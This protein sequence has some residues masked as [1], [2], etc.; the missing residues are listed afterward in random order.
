MSS[1][2]AR[3][4]AVD[5]LWR[6]HQRYRDLHGERLAAATTYYGF[7]AV[8]TL[9][10]AGYSLLRVAFRLDPSVADPVLKIIR[11]YYVP[12]VEIEEVAASSR[13]TGVVALFGLVFTGIIWV[14]ALRS[15]QRLIH[16][17]PQ[18]PGRPLPRLLLDL[19][20][21]V[22]YMVLFVVSVGISAGLLRLVSLGFGGGVVLQIL[23]WPVGLLVNLVLAA[24]L[25]VGLPRVRI[26]FRRLRWPVLVVALGITLLNIVGNRVVLNVAHAPAY[27]VVSGAVGLL[28]YLYL[29]HRMVFLAAAVV[30]VGDDAE[31]HPQR[32]AS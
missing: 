2:R 12:F 5:R 7:F 21:L 26:P 31:G 20:V 10:L 19:V 29:I 27:N 25:L 1:A 15:S 30:A 23:T 24:A 16:D 32:P 8:F 17:L 13:T 28:L 6:A 9:L 4:T 14:R 11:R 22:V 3:W 18:E